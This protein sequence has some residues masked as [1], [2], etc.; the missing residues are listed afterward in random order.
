MKITSLLL[1]LSFTFS[2]YA[3]DTEYPSARP[4][5]F[6]KEEIENQPDRLITQKIEWFRAAFDGHL[7][8]RTLGRK[9]FYHGM[10]YWTQ[11]RTEF[12]PHE[13]FHLNFR[14]IYYS[15]SISSGYTRPNEDFTLASFYGKLPHKV[16]GG[17]LESRGRSPVARERFLFGRRFS[18]TVRL[19]M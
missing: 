11:I 6:L 10:G 9:D 19:S 8:V 5:Q 3:D 17:T 14:S 12:R 2:A 4:N 18:N 13:F 7:Y 1:V 15:G 16:Y